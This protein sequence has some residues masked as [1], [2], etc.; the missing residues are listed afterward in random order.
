MH[1]PKL[2]LS[3]TTPRYIYTADLFGEELTKVYTTTTKEIYG[4]VLDDADSKMWWIENKGV[5]NGLF[6]S[7]FDGGESNFIAYLEGGYAVAF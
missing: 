5:A 2:F 3:K 1:V 6:N 7:A 4:I